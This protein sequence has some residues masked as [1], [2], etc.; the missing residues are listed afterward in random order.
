MNYKIIVILIIGF[1]SG[2][3]QIASPKDYDDCILKNMKGVDSDLGASEIRGSCRKKFPKGSE[4]RFKERDLEPIEII[5]LDGRAGLRFGNRYSGNIYNGNKNTTITS[6]TVKITAKVGE[7]ESSR[8][9]KTDVKILPLTTSDFGFDIV[10]S[11]KGS[12]Y[13]WSIVGGKGFK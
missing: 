5:S 3:D 6:V 4:Y 13:S 8:E 2:C 11:E 10:A 1:L 9:Y 12:E 7:K